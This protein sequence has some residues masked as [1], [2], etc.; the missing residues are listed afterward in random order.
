MQVLGSL[1]KCTCDQTGLHAFCRHVPKKWITNRHKFSSCRNMHVLQ[2]FHRK[3]SAYD[4]VWNVA[5]LPVQGFSKIHSD[6]KGLPLRPCSLQFSANELS[7]MHGLNVL[8]FWRLHLKSTAE[9][10]SVHPLFIVSPL[11]CRKMIIYRLPWILRTGVKPCA[12]R[13]QDPPLILLPSARL[14]CNVPRSS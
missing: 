10:V 7:P 1:G 5:T 13:L 6:H 8:L 14:I 2:N 9:A 12:V 4:L 3:R 11:G